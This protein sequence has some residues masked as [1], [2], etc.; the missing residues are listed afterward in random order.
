MIKCLSV[1]FS[2]CVNPV[3]SVRFFSILSNSHASVKP[4]KRVSPLSRAV[5][6]YCPGA[7]HFYH[8]MNSVLSSCSNTISNRDDILEGGKN[9]R[10]CLEDCWKVLTALNTA[11]ITLD[12]KKTQVGLRR[13]AF[14]GMFFDENGMSPDPK[15]VALITNATQPLSK[16]EL[17]S[18]VCQAAWNKC[19]IYAYAGIV[20]PLWDLVTSKST[21]KWLEIHEKAF[22]E[23]KDKLAKPPFWR[24]LFDIFVHWCWQDNKELN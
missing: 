10:E 22:Q 17:N 2:S 13:I 23:V 19:L 11:G 15:K 6:T 21:F 24:K 16:E 9:K 1:P 20:R 14:F 7:M 12:P 8:S 5:L 3:S 4:L 18:F